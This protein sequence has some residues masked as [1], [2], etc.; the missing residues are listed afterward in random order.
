VILFLRDDG[1]RVSSG[2][3]ELARVRVQER[4]ALAGQACELG[5]VFGRD[6]RRVGEP[7]G[8]HIDRRAALAELTFFCGEFLNK[9]C[10]Y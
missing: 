3:Q 10:D 4:N 6:R 9:N 2:R 1:R 5:A 7:G 8:P